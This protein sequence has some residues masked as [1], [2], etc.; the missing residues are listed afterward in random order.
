MN[1]PKGATQE[2]RRAQRETN[3]AAA[4]YPEETAARMRESTSVLIIINPAPKQ[5]HTNT[6]V[7][8]QN[9]EEAP[10]ASRRRQYVRQPSRQFAAAGRSTR[11]FLVRTVRAKLPEGPFAGGPILN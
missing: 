7:G 11:N 5:W 1:P 8:D 9:R 10:T 2:A 4:G 6:H 3:L